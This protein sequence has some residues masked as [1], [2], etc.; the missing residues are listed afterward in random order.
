MPPPL[1]PDDSRRLVR[2]VNVSSVN[3]FN[4]WY[5]APVTGAP[6]DAAAT[7]DD[8]GDPS[9]FLETFDDNYHPYHD[10]ILLL[11]GRA[12]AVPL[13]RQ[14]AIRRTHDR[15]QDRIRQMDQWMRDIDQFSIYQPRGELRPV[16]TPPVARTLCSKEALVATQE[17][18][19]LLAAEL[20]RIIGAIELFPHYQGILPLFD[21]SRINE[22]RCRPVHAPA[23]DNLFANLEDLLDDFLWQRRLGVAW[24][25]PIPPR[26]RSRHRGA[27]PPPPPRKR[28]KIAIMR[29]S[30][31][32]TP[33]PMDTDDNI[34][35]DATDP[36][37]RTYALLSQEEK[38]AILSVQPC[39]FFQAALVFTLY[40]T[41]TLTPFSMVLTHVNFE[42]AVI[43]GFF[44]FDR[45]QFVGQI[46]LFQRFLC[47]PCQ[48]P[49]CMARLL[50]VT[51]KLAVISRLLVH[52]KVK[53]AMDRYGS[54]LQIP[55]L[56]RIVDFKHHDLRF[57][58]TPARDSR[59][60]YKT[61]HLAR[62]KSNMVK[63]QMLEWMHVEP[64][65]QF[66]ELYFLTTIAETSHALNHFATDH[67]AHDV[68]R[69]A[70]GLR[71]SINELA[72]SLGFCRDVDLEGTPLARKTMT[73]SYHIEFFKQWNRGLAEVLC[74]QLTTTSTL[75]TLI[76]LNLNYILFTLDVDISTYCDRVLDAAVTAGALAGCEDLIECYRDVY[77]QIVADEG[78]FDAT[79][80]RYPSF[81]LRYHARQPVT[82]AVLLCLLNRKTGEVQFHNTLPFT[83]SRPNHTE[84]GLSFTRLWT[85]LGRDRLFSPSD[86]EVDDFS[87]VP[88]VANDE[89]TGG[90]VLIG[91]AKGKGGGGCVSLCELL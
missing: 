48:I 22:P 11:L 72:S 46:Q 19:S 59:L 12:H 29:Q 54:Q 65:G 13:Q 60:R 36:P 41:P 42:R 45:A 91:V 76:N 52:P 25:D 21:L 20:E 16:P 43:D 37:N 49:K 62:I 26:K 88:D 7:S 74:D 90:D 6:D 15:L 70:E 80:G 85:A 61:F 2:L 4:R 83:A 55:V 58:P 86:D 47:G 50:T 64:F 23:D 30:D 63:M 17:V 75:T 77:R 51:R 53:Q 28:T 78:H 79:G 5:Y 57:L 89:E 14:N 8:G 44:R 71:G 67:E 31:A 35:E 34:D 38:D 27:A 33:M 56:G 24:S 18:A 32:N 69:R 73:N 9:Q 10:L 84:V 82:H 3:L 87:N 68:V 40:N 81:G 1:T 39:A 66:K